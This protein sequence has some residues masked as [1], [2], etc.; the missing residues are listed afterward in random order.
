M[1]EDTELLY[2]K[3]CLRVY[4]SKNVPCAEEVLIGKQTDNQLVFRSFYVI[5]SSLKEVRKVLQEPAMSKAWN[6][7]IKWCQT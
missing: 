6:P 5:R 1:S 3:N 7:N 4:Y 2:N